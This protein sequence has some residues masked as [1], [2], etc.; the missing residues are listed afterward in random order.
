MIY[1]KKTHKKHFFYEVGLK[2][3]NFIMN[4]CCKITT[5]IKKE[6]KKIINLK[7]KSVYLII[8]ACL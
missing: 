7:L 3:T 4:K 2:L 8:R 5:L 6:V 1:I